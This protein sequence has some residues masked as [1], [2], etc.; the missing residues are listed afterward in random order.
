[1]AQSRSLTDQL[2]GSILVLA[3][4]G[5]IAMVLIGVLERVLVRWHSSQTTLA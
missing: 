2:W 5:S 4:V 1:M 3:L